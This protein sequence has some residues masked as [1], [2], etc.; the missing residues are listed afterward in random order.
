M[1][2]TL[3]NII[4]IFISAIA[5]LATMVIPLM[6]MVFAMRLYSPIIKGWFG[7]RKV[8]LILD[9]LNSECTSFHNILLPINGKTTQIDHIVFSGEMCFVIET[10]AYAGWIFGSANDNTWTQM[11]NKRS[12]ISFQSPIRQNYKHILAVK[13]FVG[14]VIIAGVV[15]FTRGEFK[16]E[17]IESV[18]YSHELKDYLLDNSKNNLFNNEHAIQ[19]LA[20]AMITEASAHREHVR[21][22]QSKYG[23]RWRI[24][25]AN[26]FLVIAFCLFIFKAE[27]VDYAKNSAPIIHP[28]ASAS[29]IHSSNRINSFNKQSSPHSIPMPQMDHR[30]NRNKIMATQKTNHDAINNKSKRLEQ[31]VFLPSVK[32]FMKD[33]VI[34]TTRSGNYQV[35]RV[36][37][38]TKDGWTLLESNSTSAT[39]LHSSG[40]RAKIKAM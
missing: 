24:R 14:D 19:G 29:V 17:R 12:K 20:K 1:E 26:S 28:V 9:G 6:L 38:V 34:V 39:F 27:V 36:G 10:K 13:E 8:R 18:L 31:K 21:R 3:V 37:S 11:F 33:K 32:G 5:P 15:V 35:I 7:E 4:P 30:V 40:E 23:G 25:L 2:K 16:S 22:L